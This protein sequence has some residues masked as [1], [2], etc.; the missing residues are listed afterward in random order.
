MTRLDLCLLPRLFLPW[1]N[2]LKDSVC[3]SP[4]DA[5]ILAGTSN[6]GELTPALG[7]AKG[8]TVAAL[9]G[10]AWPVRVTRPPGHRKASGE[11]GVAGE[12]YIHDVQDLEGRNLD[13]G[14]R[15]NSWSRLAAATLPLTGGY[16][17]ATIYLGICNCIFIFQ[18][19]YSSNEFN[20]KVHE[21]GK[22]KDLDFLFFKK[23]NT[24]GSLHLATTLRTI[25]VLLKTRQK[26]ALVSSAC[27]SKDCLKS[28]PNI[29]LHVSD[30]G[31][32]FG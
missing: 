10:G 6:S 30:R 17:P 23:V 9:A 24:N 16:K 21:L 15:G 11:A 27:N 28:W 3:G 22:C 4:W 18:Y 32:F 2:P 29:I 12:G 19:T 20:K 31:F 8:W 5:G 14:L 13:D 1:C 7:W 26:S 25:L